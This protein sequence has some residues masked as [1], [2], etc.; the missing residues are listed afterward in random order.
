M[1]NVRSGRHHTK[2][3]PPAQEEEDITTSCQPPIN[4]TTRN[5]ILPIDCCVS[6]GLMPIHNLVATKLRTTMLT[7][8]AQFQV[9]R[10]SGDACLAGETC[11]GRA[12]VNSPVANNL[13]TGIIKASHAAANSPC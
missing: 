2:P 10:P 11:G 13:S 3:P 1:V 4:H 7:T 9:H 8:G 6:N 5:N 12:F